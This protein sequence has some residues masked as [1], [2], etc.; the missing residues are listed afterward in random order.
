MRRN[1]FF[2]IFIILC[3]LRFRGSSSLLIKLLWM[4]ISQ[5]ALGCWAAHIPWHPCTTLLRKRVTFILKLILLNDKVM[6][7]FNCLIHSC[8]GGK[9]EVSSIQWRED[10]ELVEKK[11]I[12]KYSTNSPVYE[13][14]LQLCR[15]RFVLMRSGLL[16]LYSDIRYFCLLLVL[17]GKDSCCP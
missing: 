14:R 3:Y 10:D 2:I 1:N 17:G 5:L 15:K 16:F 9:P 7:C 8:R 11:G 4:R 13:L 6:P 12:L